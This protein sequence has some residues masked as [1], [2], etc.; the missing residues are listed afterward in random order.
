MVASTPA[1]AGTLTLAGGEGIAVTFGAI[2]DRGLE[3]VKPR[4]ACVSAVGS[5]S[6]A[7][8]EGAELAGGAALGVGIAA[9]VGEGA[10]AAG[11]D[12]ALAVG[13]AS[14][15]AVAIALGG[16]GVGAGGCEVSLLAT[17]DAPA[18]VT[19]RFDEHPVAASANPSAQTTA[20][21]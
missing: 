10:G 15:V 2:D 4:V 14:D 9:G 12:V 13:V 5:P 7:Y 19:Q 16:A 8:G 1:F 21:A 20:W 3:P 18:G 11:I 6:A 17:G